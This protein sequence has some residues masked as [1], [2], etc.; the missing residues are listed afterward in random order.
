MDAPRLIL[1]LRLRAPFPHSALLSDYQEVGR[2]A[3]MTSHPYTDV[4]LA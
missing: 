1:G 2:A 4:G 3:L